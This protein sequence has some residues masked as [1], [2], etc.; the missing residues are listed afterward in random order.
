MATKLQPT[1]NEEE[2]FAPKMGQG[3]SH[4]QQGVAGGRMTTPSPLPQKKTCKLKL[5]NKQG[6]NAG[7]TIP[8]EE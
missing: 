7:S 3:Q 6:I 5:R 8:R 2:P 4:C 1:H